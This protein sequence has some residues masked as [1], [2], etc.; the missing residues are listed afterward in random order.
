[1]SPIAK[2]QAK[3]LGTGKRAAASG[4][5]SALPHT[6]DAGFVA[7]ASSLHKLFEEAGASLAELV[8]SLDAGVEACLWED[9]VLDADNLPGLAF[10]WLNELIALA[11]IHHGAI[12]TTTVEGLDGPLTGEGN[13]PWRLRGRVGL[14]TAGEPGVRLLHQPK[15][16]TYHR[17][18]V[19]RK[20]LCWTMQAYVDL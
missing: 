8:A 3:G 19:E 14:R 7:A 13:G 6:A 4:T 5:H 16:A 17:L 18:I 20:G 9:V 15:S 11:D 12:V 2:A 10:A 1:M